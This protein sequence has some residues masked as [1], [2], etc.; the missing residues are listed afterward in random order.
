MTSTRLLCIWLVMLPFLAYGNIWDNLFLGQGVAFEIPV[1][2]TMTL[3]IDEGFG[4][5]N[6]K[7]IGSAVENC[8]SVVQS[9]QL[10]G[11]SSMLVGDLG[12]IDYQFNFTNASLF[13]HSPMKDCLAIQDQ[14]LNISSYYY[15]FESYLELMTL[16]IS[17]HEVADYYTLDSKDLLQSVVV[18]QNVSD[19]GDVVFY[20][21]KDTEEI[22]KFEVTTANKTYMFN[23][24]ELEPY[25][26]KYEDFLVP[27]PWN[28]LQATNQ[29]LDEIDPEELLDEAK[30]KN[31]Q[32]F[33]L[34][35]FLPINFTL[36]SFKKEP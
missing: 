16:L 4:K 33:T 18:P 29:T 31:P 3:S 7:M 20:F 22:E 34:M 1:N 5:V 19:L 11:F 6:L 32:L 14:R 8:L 17:R 35:K 13:I 21:D 10:G 27:E 9:F 23:V 12:T 26:T 28:C 15:S 25:Q 30:K 36:P 24:V 2:F